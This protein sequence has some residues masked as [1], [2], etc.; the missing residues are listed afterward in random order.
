VRGKEGWGRPVVTFRRG[1]SGVERWVSF[2]VRVRVRGAGAGAV[3]GAGCLGGCRCC[4]GVLVGGRWRRN[5]IVGVLCC[6]VVC[7]SWL[8]GVVVEDLRGV[9]CDC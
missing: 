2:W 3:A 6:V 5:V 9:I 4:F 7:G 1:C 8:G